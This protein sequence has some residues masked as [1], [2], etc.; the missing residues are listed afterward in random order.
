MNERR[1]ETAMIHYQCYVCHATATCV[2]N[3]PANLAWHDHM[4]NHA[5]PKHYGAWTWT[6]QQ[7]DYD[8]Y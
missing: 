3:E 5:L 1:R 4:A 7:L 2:A 8:S 6:V